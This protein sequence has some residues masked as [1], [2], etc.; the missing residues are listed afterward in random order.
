MADFLGVPASRIP[1]DPE[2]LSDP[3]RE[4]VA[5]AAQSRKRAIREDVVPEQG[6]GQK[7]GSGYSARLIEFVEDHR[8]ITQAAQYAPSLQRAIDCLSRIVQR[9]HSFLLRGGQ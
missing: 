3:K 7:V 2:Q 5:L 4:I 1:S 6:A 9:Y 8:D